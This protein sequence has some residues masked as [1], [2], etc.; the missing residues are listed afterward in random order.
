MRPTRAAALLGA[1][2]AAEAACSDITG[3]YQDGG[4]IGGHVEVVQADCRFAATWENDDLYAIGSVSGTSIDMHI[5]PRGCSCTNNPAT[6]D[7]GSKAVKFNDG[8]AKWTYVGPVG[9]ADGN[10]R[11][12]CS[13]VQGVF[14]DSGSEGGN[15]E[16]VQAGCHFAATW[17]SSTLFALGTISGDDIHMGITDFGCSCGDFPA[18]VQSSGAIR[19]NDGGAEWSPGGPLPVPGPPAPTPP[20]TPSPPATPQPP[21]PPAPPVPSGAVRL[22]IDTD[23]GFDVDDVAA[24]C[25]AHA[26]H[27]LGEASLLAVVHDTGFNKGIGAVSVIN[28]YYGHDS[29]ALGAYKGAF[30]RD[31]STQD[32][33]V[34]DLVN[35]YDSPVKDYDD[36][37]E[38]VETLR[39]TLAAQPDNSVYIASIGMTT[40]MR[41]LMQSKGDSHSSLDGPALVSKKVRSIW[42]MDGMYNFGCAEH[43]SGPAWLGDDNGCRGSAQIAL[44]LWPSNVEQVFQGEGGDIITGDALDGCVDNS[45]PCRKAFMDWT[46]G[47]GRSSWDPLTVLGAVRGASRAHMDL[48]GTGG[49]MTANE[50]GYEDWHPGSGHPESKA[51]YHDNAQNSIKND[52]NDLLCRAAKLRALRANATRTVGR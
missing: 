1:A 15:L 16:V 28:H 4:S 45:D 6:Y 31:G 49:H 5:T 24:V 38:A 37:P 25:A 32:N 27:D 43:D 21:A 11:A 12:D 36:V 13:N 8:G 46:G 17:V 48:D 18:T 7:T 34:S 40:N 2:A 44:D 39:K 20:P 41:D 51:S 3:I 33:Y 47:N 14:K 29:V 42:W 22:I 10:A 23:M 30:G 9:S 26:L 35:N 52:I 50:G 19:F